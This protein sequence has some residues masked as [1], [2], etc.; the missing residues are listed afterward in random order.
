MTL[1][2]EDVPEYFVNY[3]DVFMEMAEAVRLRVIYNGK[4]QFFMFTGASVF[5]SRETLILS[6][7]RRSLAKL[8]NFRSRLLD[9]SYVNYYL[10]T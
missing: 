6:L 10:V 9:L 8:R 3:S 1:T 2:R 7:V 5:C 4:K